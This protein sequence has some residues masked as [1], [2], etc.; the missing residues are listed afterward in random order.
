METVFLGGLPIATHPE[1][2][3]IWTASGYR[4]RTQQ[5]GGTICR[6][7][8]SRANCVVARERAMGMRTSTNTVGRSEK[9]PSRLAGTAPCVSATTGTH[10]IDQLQNTAGAIFAVLIALLLCSETGATWW[11][12]QRTLL[13]K[14]EIQAD[15]RG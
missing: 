2:L 13:L 1:E 9:Y 12:P 5:I 3:V 6:K 14:P 15:A 10:S 11:K 4:L 7:S 8:A